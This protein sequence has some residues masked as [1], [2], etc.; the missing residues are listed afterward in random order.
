MLECKGVGN[1][2]VIVAEDRANRLKLKNKKRNRR[3][4]CHASWHH[5]GNHPF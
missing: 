3:D 5:D 1:Y 2:L 4:G